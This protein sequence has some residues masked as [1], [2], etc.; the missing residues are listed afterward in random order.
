M[1]EGTEDSTG[2]ERTGQDGRGQGQEAGRGEQR[3][4]KARDMTGDRG[5]A[6]SGWP[7]V[8][9]RSQDLGQA[10]QFRGVGAAP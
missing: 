3:A 7:P 9:E 5:V 2:Q 1:G 4:D 6:S 8:K 10:P